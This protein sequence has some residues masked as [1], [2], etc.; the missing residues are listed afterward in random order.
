MTLLC[1]A[2]LMAGIIHAKQPSSPDPK[3]APMR[4][5]HWGQLNILATTDT[6]GWHAGHLQEPS[7][8]GDWGDYISFAS[9]MRR[10]AASQDLDLLLV[11]T[12]DRVDGNGL[13]DGSDPKGT[14]T[15][16]IIK[17]QD[18]D[19]LCSG[20]HELYRREAA[21]IEYNTTVPDFRDR[22]LASNLDIA[23]PETGK[24]TQ[25]SR[26][27]KIFN[28]P[29]Q[30]LRILSM[31]FL[32]DFTG[33]AENVFV[34]PVEETVK[35]AWFQEAIKENDIDVFIIIGHVAPRSQEW[36]AV[37][38]EIRKRHW[39]TPILFFS[40][41]SHVRDFV[42]LDSKAVA[43][44][45]GR[46]LE[47]IG[48]LSIS[49]IVKKDL[50]AKFE[51]RAAIEERNQKLSWFLPSSL[52]ARFE[53]PVLPELT[54]EEQYLEYEWAR[55]ITINRRY[56]DNNQLGYQHHTGTNASTFPTEHGLNVSS[57]ISEA[58]KTLDLDKNYGCAP[59]TYF[60]NLAPY[61]HEDSLF[62]LMVDSLLPNV[63]DEH[64]HGSAQTFISGNPSRPKIALMNTGGLRFDVFKGAFTR[65]TVYIVSP[66]ENRWRV[67]RNV[68]WRI[69]KH[70]LPLINSGGEVMT[71]EVKA[72]NFELS[73]KEEKLLS[74]VD[75]L[76]PP[77]QMSWK[78][79]RVYS[80]TQRIKQDHEAQK[81]IGG[82]I[83]DEPEVELTPGYT[84]SD[85][86]DFN[87]DDTVHS[88][89]NYYRV[90]NAIQA[91]IGWGGKGDLSDDDSIDVVFLDFVQPWI[92][93]ALR[94]LGHKVEEE[95]V[96]SYLEGKGF[97]TMI[98]EW[99][100]ENW[101][102]NCETGT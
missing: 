21:E 10:I 33:G 85:D 58:R 39:D 83:A 1:L 38:T 65:D 11:D 60:V 64:K 30:K 73:K 87:G 81:L 31:G 3:P 61:P 23:H 51:A 14:Y 46:Y 90:P 17:Q 66:F 76:A 2:G 67:I 44:Q 42:Q 56:I 86:L 74:Q 20:N 88:P 26:R 102:D 68:S 79:E 28:T 41:H 7:Y 47:T 32:F 45:S 80:A 91:N 94:Y 101:S 13:Y 6:H 12:G 15:S 40:G 96:E 57:T 35:T 92:V 37:Y 5:L 75:L 100:T 89:L 48:F 9:H 36:K 95:D 18:I 72:V 29:K 93:T 62:T 27:Y 82:E 25:M 52:R 54:E 16:D 70:V 55:G 24:R 99:V 69:A 19:L 63:L 84:T 43:L 8:S 97:T 78:E 34:T 49:G 59:K 53:S 98:K 71:K 77:E 4:P 50:A 22:Y